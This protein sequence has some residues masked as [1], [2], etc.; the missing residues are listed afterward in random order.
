MM[1]TRTTT[2]TTNIMIIFHQN[3]PTA[4][5]RNVPP[6]NKPVQTQLTGSHLICERAPRSPGPGKTL[7]VLERALAGWLAAQPSVRL[8]FA[9][10]S[11]L[12]PAARLAHF[13]LP[14]NNIE[15]HGPTAML[16]NS[17]QIAALAAPAGSRAARQARSAMRGPKCK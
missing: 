8:L 3:R 13:H 9:R 12:V 5:A 6:P 10:Q 14:L 4:C 7:L 1:F 11:I 2:G 15:C 17:P 16:I